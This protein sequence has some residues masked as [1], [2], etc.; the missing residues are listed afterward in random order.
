MRK[1][2]LRATVNLTSLLFEIAAIMITERKSEVEKKILRPTVQQILLTRELVYKPSGA[3]RMD[4]IVHLATSLPGYELSYFQR[5]CMDQILK[6]V[7]PVVFK[8]CSAQDLA[9]YFQKTNRVMTRKRMCF[10]TTS[11]RSGKT[12]LLTIMAAIFLIVIPNVELL[13]WSLYNETAELFGRTMLK[14]IIDLGYGDFARAS[15]NHVIFTRTREDVRTIYTMGSQNPNVSYY[16]FYIDIY[17]LSRVSLCVSVDH[18]FLLTKS[19]KT[20]KK[21]KHKKNERFALHIYIVGRLHTRGA[22][23]GVGIRV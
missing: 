11:R 22:D 18:L 21:D 15:T 5:C 13:C 20:T 3:E 2:K 23:A 14:W 12:D 17:I 6:I 16:C 7:A 19:T 1:G 4:K 10:M 8:G 9:D